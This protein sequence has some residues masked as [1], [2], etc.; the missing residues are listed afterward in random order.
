MRDKREIELRD[1]ANILGFDLYGIGHEE[2]VIA[3]R[4]SGGRREAIMGRN[5]GASLD[6]IEE[7]LDRQER[8]ELDAWPAYAGGHSQGGGIVGRVL[9]AAPLKEQLANIRQEIAAAD[10]RVDEQVGVIGTLAQDGGDTLS[11]RA[12]LAMLDLHIRILREQEAAI[13]EEISRG[14]SGWG[15]RTTVWGRGV[16]PDPQRDWAA[17][18]DGA[19]WGG[20][21]AVIRDAAGVSERMAEKCA[22]DLP[23]VPRYPFTALKQSA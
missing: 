17:P 23:A 3:R 5:G 11:A 14:N 15:R 9:M 8:T 20:E 4:L 21:G 2:Y 6:S 16:A 7:W 22:A 13:E 18:G 12:T 1:R 10:Q 19:G